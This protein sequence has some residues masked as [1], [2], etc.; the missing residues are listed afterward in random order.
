[1]PD[2]VTD[3]RARRDLLRD[4]V[5]LPGPPGQEERVRDYLSRR[6][7]ERGFAC[8][9]DAKGNLLV[10][11]GAAWPERPAVVV[12]AH[13]D[14]IALLVTGIEPNGALRVAPLG[15]AHPWKWGEGPVEA[16]GRGG[17]MLP[18]VLSFGSIHTTAP[19][20]VAEQARS[21]VVPTWERARVLTGLPPEALA[22]AGVRPG[23]RVVVARERRGLWDLGGDLVA[24]YFLDDRA[25]L[26]AWLLALAALRDEPSSPD[27]L[28]A[29]TASEEV[30]GEGAS[31]LLH[32]SRPPVCVA[33]EI[34]PSTPDAPFPLDANP[35]VWVS[36]T[37]AA[38]DPRDLDLLDAAGRELGLALHWQ[39]VTR[40]GSD[41]SCAAARGLCAR[42]VT[43]AFAAENSHGFEVMHKDAPANLARL[44]VAYLRRLPDP[45][46]PAEGSGHGHE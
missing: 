32:A 14:E 25:D 12:T 43:L 19:Q 9:T 39:A 35:T 1:M 7:V 41:A 4:L 45:A 46:A 3:N 8:R 23:T 38:M 37:Y 30:G 33:L 17:E 34:G 11:A 31:Y 44:L 29:A 24:S 16:L 20:S 6:V 40:G 18:G 2:D 10:A 28:F 21:G 15:G 13:L 5:S 22:A 42:P 26:V 27:V 36:D